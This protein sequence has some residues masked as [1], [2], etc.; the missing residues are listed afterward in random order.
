[1]S[2]GCALTVVVR[3]GYGLILEVGYL[4]CSATTASEIIVAGTYKKAPGTR[5]GALVR[6]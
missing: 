4:D 5:Y 1:M 2:L 3:A 6:R